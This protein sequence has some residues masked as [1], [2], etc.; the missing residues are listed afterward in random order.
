VRF[1]GRAPEP[2]RPRFLAVSPG[3]FATM[4]IPLVSGR[5]FTAQDIVAGLPTAVI[6][7]QA[8]VRQFFRGEDAL[9]KRLERMVDDDGN[10]DAQDI[11]G[12]V[13]DAKYN[14]LREAFAPTIYQPAGGVG[15]TVEVRTTGNPLAIAA[16]LRQGI[17]R[18]DASLRVTGITLENR[19][20]STRPCCR[21]GCWRCWGASLRGSGGAG[22]GGPQ[23]RAQLRGGAATR[24]IGI[25]VA[26]SATVASVIRVMAGDVAVTV[27]IGFVGGLAGGL[28]LARSLGSLLF[29]V[30]PSDFGSV[31]LPLA[32]LLLAS[33]AM[34]A[35]RVDPM[36]ALMYE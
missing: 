19:R 27:A 36:E 29:E 23:R 6:V 22:C 16:A 4:Q 7:N 3:F 2:I 32:S 30:K 15:S 26:L 17:E 8:F 14:N 20:A 9:G 28:A 1:P 10:Y 11:V 34:R 18:V 31:A 33:A 5:E 35:A 24:E 13:R 12:V 25:R 21:S